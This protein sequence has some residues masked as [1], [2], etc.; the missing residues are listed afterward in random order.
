[1][2]LGSTAKKVQTIADRAEKTFEQLV[3]LRKRII[4]LEQSMDDTA[5]RVRRLERRTEV[6]NAVLQAIAEEHDIDVDDVV[7]QMAIK[8]AE[9]DGDTKTDRD[10]IPITDAETAVEDAETDED[11][12][13]SDTQ[14]AEPGESS[15][16]TEEQ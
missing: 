9:T 12:G 16:A 6:Q 13:E 5:E 3:E 10:E 7:A 14:S 2:G 1:M 4:G 15:T 8:E 11:E